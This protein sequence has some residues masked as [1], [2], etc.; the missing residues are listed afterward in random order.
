[1]IFAV[2]PEKACKPLMVQDIKLT[3]L[4]ADLPVSDG[5]HQGY[6]IYG[7]D[8]LSA[9]I[10][11]VSFDRAS[12]YTGVCGVFLFQKQICSKFLNVASKQYLQAL[13]QLPDNVFLTNTVM[14]P[15]T[16]FP[17]LF[18]AKS[19]S[20]P[21]FL[22]AILTCAEDFSETANSQY[23]SDEDVE[24][25][26]ACYEQWK[27]EHQ[28]HAQNFSVI[29]QMNGFSVMQDMYPFLNQENLKKL[30]TSC[31]F[32]CDH[33]CLSHAYIVNGHL[34]RLNNEDPEVYYQKA[35]SAGS[36][37]LVCANLMDYGEALKERA[38]QENDKTKQEVFLK[39]SLEYL[40]PYRYESSRALY[41]SA[42]IY[43]QYFCTSGNAPKIKYYFELF[44]NNLGILPDFR[45]VS[46]N[47]EKMDSILPNTQKIKYALEA[48]AFCSYYYLMDGKLDQAKRFLQSISYILEKMPNVQLLDADIFKKFM[49]AYSIDAE[50]VK[51]NDQIKQCYDLVGEQSDHIVLVC[52]SV[53]LDCLTTLHERLIV[54][55]LF[56][57][58]CFL[59]K[60][61]FAMA[62]QHMQIARDIERVYLKTENLS[63]V[64]LPIIFKN[65][66]QACF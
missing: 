31:D 12:P 50:D 10:Q 29:K 32:L 58:L 48:F 30:K 37:D 66:Y 19:E 17:Q 18:D 16:F 44:L 5:V 49:S 63:S 27:S 38:L 52:P 22:N 65:L 1:M 47:T 2:Q 64:K 23:V 34:A 13:L 41:L 42:T 55:D 59:L 36:N 54:A 7:F 15:F 39:K 60:G 6:N 4:L 33:F 8:Q 9:V 11:G 28:K 46:I 25:F 62:I 53:Y 56:Q 61:N 40:E 51:N 14:Q 43:R 20:E 21:I 35:L 24:N 57:S 3:T 26:K 45:A